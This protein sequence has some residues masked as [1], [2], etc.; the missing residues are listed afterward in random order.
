MKNRGEI[1]ITDDP[2]EVAK[3]GLDAMMN[4]EGGVISGWQN[5]LMMVKLMP[6]GMLAGRQWQSIRDRGRRPEASDQGGEGLGID[7]TVPV[8]RH[9]SM[10]NAM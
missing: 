10:I 8:E 1:L 3:N 6:R 9:K 7:K 4:G 5:K 2:R